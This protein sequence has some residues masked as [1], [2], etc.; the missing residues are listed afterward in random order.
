MKFPALFFLFFFTLSSAAAA[1]DVDA[2]R[3]ANG[4]FVSSAVVDSFMSDQQV[5]VMIKLK[6]ES[7]KGIRSKTAVSKDPANF[8]SKLDIKVLQAELLS[9][10]SPD[11]VGREIRIIHEL[12]NIPWVTGTISRTALEKL[13]TNP[14]VAMIVEDRPVKASL[15]QSSR[16]IQADVAHDLGYTG[17]G[18]AVAVLDSGIDTDNPFLQDDLIHEEC[19]LSQGGCPTGGIRASGPG[20]AE[21]DVGHGT[22]V[23]GVITS[24][25]PPYEGIAPDAEIVAVKVLDNN[26]EGVFSDIIAA[27]DWVITH[28]DI[29]GIDIINM[30]FGGLSLSG[31]CDRQA[32]AGASITAAAKEAGI[33]FFAASGNEGSVSGINLPACLSSV[34]SVGMVYDTYAEGAISWGDPEVCRDDF[35]SEDEIVCASNVSFVLDLLAPGAFITSVGVGGGTETAGG[36]SLAAS[37]AS[38]VAALMLEKNPDLSPD[39]IL[40]NLK[41][42]GKPIYDARIYQFFPRIDAIEAFSG[43]EFSLPVYRFRTG[44]D[45]YFYTASEDE[46]E[47]IVS[48]L[49]GFTFEGVAFYAYWDSV[50]VSTSPVY[51][52]R[53]GEGSYFYTA[54]EDE[55]EFI[56]ST[57]P[58]F[59][60][61]GVAFY[62]YW[63]SVSVSTS[64]VYRF[65]TGEGSYF[66]TASKDEKEF[67]VSTLPSFTFEGV[68][69]YAESRP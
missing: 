10:F 32:P 49:P 62:A 2:V 9:S 43:L 25:R 11:E 17:K 46:K 60:F 34:I 53:T 63:D 16:L 42:S 55:K 50:S 38:A 41:S 65:R 56:V 8:I 26:G 37:H 39:Q 69:F 15:V 28:K 40:E 7:D 35:I 29:Y 59:T 64:P 20:S 48:T 18:V 21:D 24:S 67:I 45:S 51:R 30:S 54:S 58:G 19:F 66:Y 22:L 52:F 27:I 4:V 44:E 23:S 57:L 1:K 47:F 5:L 12:D 68:A 3:K 61:E 36:T 33:T 6:D 14:N 13:K 31:T